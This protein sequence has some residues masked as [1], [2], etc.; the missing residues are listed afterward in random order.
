MASDALDLVLRLPFFDGLPLHVARVVRPTTGQRHDVIDHVTPPSVG[1]PGCSHEVLLGG[2]APLDTTPVVAPH[3]GQERRRGCAFI[4]G[5]LNRLIRGGRSLTA[6]GRWTQR[7]GW[8]GRRSVIYV[9]L[10]AS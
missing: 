6:L 10:P 8:L 5:R 2:L 3:T 1:V 7:V 9:A 4:L